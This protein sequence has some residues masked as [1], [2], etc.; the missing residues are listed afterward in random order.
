MLDGYKLLEKPGFGHA[1]ECGVLKI[2]QSNH[3]WM[4]MDPNT[5]H[6]STILGDGITLEGLFE[7]TQYTVHPIQAEIPH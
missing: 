4:V 3:A 5:P 2:L 7:H 6:P 1:C